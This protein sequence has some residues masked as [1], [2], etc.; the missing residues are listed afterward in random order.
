VAGNGTSGYSGDGGAATSAKI[1]NPVH[2]TLDRSG[3]IFIAD[4]NNNRIR[5]V[6]VATG[7]IT[8]VAGNETRADAGDGG[9]ATS[10][11]L[12]APV[13]VAIDAYGNFYIAEYNGSRIR[14]VTGG[15]GIITTVV[16]N[17]TALVSPASAHWRTCRKA[18]RFGNPSRTDF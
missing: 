13:A 15:T 17:G 5:E 14:K 18:H 3:N 4:Y 8:T 10:A 6:T 16:G 1:W 11:E 9:A 7:I 2:V 12:N